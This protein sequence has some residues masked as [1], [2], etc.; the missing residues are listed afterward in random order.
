MTV[1]KV[2]LYQTLYSP[3]VH[4]HYIPVHV[5]EHSNP[6]YPHPLPVPS[7][8]VV[9]DLYNGLSFYNS[10]HIMVI[11]SNTTLYIYTMMTS[12]TN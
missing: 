6:T 9:L 5:Y 7:C 8:D 12:Q 11:V 10:L 4:F 1:L 3:R 2:A